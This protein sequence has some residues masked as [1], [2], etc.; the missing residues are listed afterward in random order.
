MKF[1]QKTLKG[2]PHDHRRLPNQHNHLRL[3]KGKEELNRGI[4]VGKMKFR[5][6][7]FRL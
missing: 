1:A 7:L 5:N 4:N 2:T 3:L 6:D